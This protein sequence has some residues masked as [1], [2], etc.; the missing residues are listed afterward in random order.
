MGAADHLPCSLAITSAACTTSGAGR[1]LGP[2]RAALAE[3]EVGAAL[4]QALIGDARA[5]VPR[6]TASCI[7]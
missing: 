3:R 6:R 2:E 5:G 4:D 1:W 7:A